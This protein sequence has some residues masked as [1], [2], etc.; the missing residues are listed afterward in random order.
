MTDDEKLEQDMR[1]G[2]TEFGS[3][4]GMYEVREYTDFQATLKAF[5]P[6]TEAGEPD[7]LRPV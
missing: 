3:A 6:V 4:E 7:P 1:S 2:L 5:L